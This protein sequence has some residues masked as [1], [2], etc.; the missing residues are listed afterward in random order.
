MRMKIKTKTTPFSIRKK[1]RLKTG[2]QSIR[3]KT[4]PRAREYYNYKIIIIVTKVGPKTKQNRVY[5]IRMKIRPKTRC[6]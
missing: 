1:I 3:I 2:V 6:L 5:R 4:R